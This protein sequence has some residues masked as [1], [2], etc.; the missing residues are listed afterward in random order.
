SRRHRRKATADAIHIAALLAHFLGEDRGKTAAAEN[1]VA[2]IQRH[3]IRMATPDALLA[4]HQDGLAAVEVEMLH[5]A[6]VDV[7]T[8]NRRGALTLRQCGADLLR[9]RFRFGARQVAGHG[10]S[11]EYTSELQSR[12][13]LV[14]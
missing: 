6:G 12:E 7:G 8:F 9:Q 4:E 2:D 13:N 14:C 11:E 10:R 5:L 1:L 3:I